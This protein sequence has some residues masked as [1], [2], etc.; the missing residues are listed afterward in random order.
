[1]TALGI[2]A[3]TD[4]LSAYLDGELPAGDGERVEAHLGRC[5]S[6]R[7]EL[8]SLR[9]VVDTLRRLDRA[10]PPPA[11]E[12]H[13]ARRIALEGRRTGLLARFEDEAALFRPRI[14]ALMPFMLAFALAAML[15]FFALTLVE[16]EHRGPVL[17]VPPPGAARIEGGEP[18][19]VHTAVE[20][21]KGETGT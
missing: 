15:F 17:V 5:P 21:G 3:T 12:Q 19:R 14:A 1:M 13:V 10:A 6:C 9:R 4:L 7:A 20:A 16:M 11:L 18:V 2:H 8:D